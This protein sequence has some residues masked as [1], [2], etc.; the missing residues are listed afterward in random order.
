MSNE[1]KGVTAVYPDEHSGSRQLYERAKAVMPG[2]NTRTTV[3]FDPFPIYADRALGCRMWDVDGNVYYDCINNFASMIHGHGQPEMVSEVAAQLPFGTAYGASTVHEIELAELLMERLP[4]NQKVRFANSGTEAVMM[5]IKAARAFTDRPKI[6]KIEGAYHGSYDFAEV[7][8]DSN[9]ENWG[10]MPLSTAYAKGTPQ[11]VVDDVIAIAFNDEDAVRQ[12]MQA[13]GSEIAAVL[14][15]PMPNRAGLIPA[16][17]EFLQTV[18]D[19]AHAKGALVIFDEVITFRLGHS[20]AQGLWDLDP[21]ITALGKIIGGGFPIGAIAGRDE[22]MEVF[23]PTRGKPALPHG[24][25]FTANPVAMRAGLA[26]MRGLTPEV[27]AHLDKIGGLIRDGVNEAFR[28]H[29][30]VGQCV[31][32]GSLFKLH[33]TDQEVTDYRSVYPDAAAKKKLDHLHKGLLSRG[34]LAANYGLFA[35]STPMLEQ[36]AENILAA[37]SDTLGEIARAG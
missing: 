4:G 1:N 35:L 29:D 8:L 6:V 2:G 22:V 26:A 36:D 15:D 11:G 12:V 30:L 16:R 27:F 32:M 25:T 3:Y 14:V 13:H 18:I 33:F 19:E 5:A 17:R 10:N 9:P 23:D 31:G 24:G 20:G 7:S 28:Q 21:D 34:V 37:I